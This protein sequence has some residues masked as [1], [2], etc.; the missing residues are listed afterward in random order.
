MAQNIEPRKDASPS[1]VPETPFNT[2]AVQSALARAGD[3]ESLRGPNVATI[4]EDEEPE[5]EGRNPASLLANVSRTLARRV[6]EQG[7]PARP[8]RRSLILP[9]TQ[10]ARRRESD[11]KLTRTLPRPCPPLLRTPPC[12]TWSKAG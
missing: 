1:A 4:G 12:S 5:E 2:P 8:V 9:S 7:L 10:R 6:A 3:R 11:R